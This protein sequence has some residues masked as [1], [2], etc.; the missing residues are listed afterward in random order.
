MDAFELSGSDTDE[1]EPPPEHGATVVELI[2]QGCGPYE[3]GTSGDESDTELDPEHFD[4]MSGGRAKNYCNQYIREKL[5]RAHFE[6]GPNAPPPSQQPR[7]TNLMIRRLEH[8]RF[9][10]FIDHPIQGMYFNVNAMKSEV[11]AKI[12][13]SNATMRKNA[14][15]NFREMIIDCVDEKNG[16]SPRARK[17][18]KVAKMTGKAMKGAYA[19]F[20]AK[21]TAGEAGG[22]GSKEDKEVEDE[23]DEGDEDEEEVEEVVAKKAAKKSP[24]KKVAEVVAKKSKVAQVVAKKAANKQSPK[25]KVAKEVVAMVATKRK[26]AEMAPEECSET[27]QARPR[28]PPPPCFL[29]RPPHLRSAWRRTCRFIPA[30]PSSLHHKFSLLFLS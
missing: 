18:K 17:T 7:A 19:E 23:G 5:I 3:K 27:V 12:R 6:V 28:P 10:R 16:R 21:Q 8:G 20:F 11:Y 1:V 24:R 30:S 26:A 2:E 14:K 25:K 15:Q 4:V 29:H 9:A 22:A 13:K